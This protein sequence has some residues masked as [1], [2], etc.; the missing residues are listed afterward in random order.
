MMF[1][2]VSLLAL[3]LS[4][5][6]P[7]FPEE[8]DSTTTSAVATTVDSTDSTSTGTDNSSSTGTDNSSSSSIGTITDN[9]TSTGTDN[10]TGTKGYDYYGNH[11]VTVKLY[12]YSNGFTVLFQPVSGHFVCGVSNYV[13]QNGT[14]YTIG[15]IAD[16]QA[17]YDASSYYNA[18]VVSGSF[19]GCGTYLVDTTWFIS[20]SRLGFDPTASYQV[21]LDDVT[22]DGSTPMTFSFTA[23]Q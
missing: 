20:S 6:Y 8:T 13:I 15:S 1:S 14:Q 19:D 2:V 3:V 10:Y 18:Y 7:S 9:A 11:V 5:C 22:S 16:T 23:T 4:G 21:I 17:I 12:A